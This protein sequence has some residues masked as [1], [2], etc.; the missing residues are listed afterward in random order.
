[1]LLQTNETLVSSPRCRLIY[2]NISVDTTVCMIDPPQSGTSRTVSGRDWSGPG[3][4]RHHYLSRHTRL[5][6]RD[7]GASSR[8]E[9]I[10]IGAHKSCKANASVSRHVGSVT[11]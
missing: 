11:V 3:A 8:Q 6:L 2:I 10:F 4:Q 1:M 5:H 7:G 9:D